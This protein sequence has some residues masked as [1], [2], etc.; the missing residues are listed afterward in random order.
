[1]TQATC[2]TLFDKQPRSG[3]S[4]KLFAP[5]QRLHG[6]EFPGIGVGLATA[7]R[8]VERHRGRIRAESAVGEGA[9]FL[10]TLPD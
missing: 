3:A 6:S 7:Q 4:H 10:F 8:I 9:T 2:R 5:F 1:L